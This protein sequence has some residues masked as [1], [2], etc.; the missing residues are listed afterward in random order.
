MKKLLS[1]F[2]VGALSITVIVGCGGGGGGG[3]VPAGITYTGV[4]TQAL[5]D[6]N[7]AVDIVLETYEG[8]DTTSELNVLGAVSENSSSVRNP[9][10]FDISA[11]F[12]S[13]IHEI[14]SSAGQNSEYMGAVRTESDTINGS[15]GGSFSYNLT[16]DDQ[17]GNFSGALTFNNFCE[18]GSKANGSMNLSANI[19]LNTGEFNYLEMTF[20]NFTMTSGQESI[21]MNGRIDFNL[22]SSPITMTFSFIYKDNNLNKTY[23]YENFAYEYTEGFGFVDMT[24]S[25]R[26][27]HHDYGYVDIVT[28]SPLRIN[29]SDFYPSSG[30]V[31]FTGDS[32]TKARLNVINS[33]SFIV[34]ADTDGDGSYDDYISEAILWSSI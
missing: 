33:S 21:S 6:E 31:I 15:C 1:L 23:K 11:Y 17:T 20:T 4:T 25:G 28:E 12:Q 13:V 19:N 18:Q 10:F 32:G 16:G 8:V 2:F 3:G 30:S 24:F 29:G 7:N 26:F 9:L 22:Q 34:E 5:I 27:Y 14:E